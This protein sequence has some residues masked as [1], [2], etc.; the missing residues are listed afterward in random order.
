MRSSEAEGE[1]AMPKKQLEKVSI[2]DLKKEME[3][4]GYSKGA[5]DIIAPV[6]PTI[7]P[8]QH[9]LQLEY[10]LY[11]AVMP[12]D[13]SSIAGTNRLQKDN[14]QDVIDGHNR[15]IEA[16]N[17]SQQKRYILFKTQYLNSEQP[18][19]N[20]VPLDKAVPMTRD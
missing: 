20:W 8:G 15:I 14:T 19:N 17:Q 4:D 6:A 2:D 13:S 3:E 11:I 18:L 5:M 7:I 1:D 16:L 10:A 9:H 12:D